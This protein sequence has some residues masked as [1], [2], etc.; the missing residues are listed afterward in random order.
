LEAVD[1]AVVLGLAEDGLDHRLALAVELA[2]RALFIAESSSRAPG[3]A[4]V[5]N[6]PA[7]ILLVEAI[8]AYIA[9]T[10]CPQHGLRALGDPQIARALGLIREHPDEPWTVGRLAAA[11][12]LSR[13]AFAAR[14]NALVGTSPA[15]YLARWR[16]TRAAGFLRDGNLTMSEIASHSGYRSEA[17]FNRAFKRLEG[18]TPGSY[19]RRAARSTR[20]ARSPRPRP[21]P[22]RG[23][24]PC[25]THTTPR[26]RPSRT[27]SSS[28]ASATAAPPRRAAVPGPR[29]SA[30]GPPDTD[31]GDHRK[32]SPQAALPPTR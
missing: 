17:S 23:R 31:Q 15:G 6:R 3:A 28:P 32:F 25:S 1:A 11:V 7:D 4:V 27:S 29:S 5:V 14:F 19:R 22:L 20:A 10:D 18:V 24:P 21:R 9:G 16:M 30:S 2:G 26:R 13:S 8:R 12:A